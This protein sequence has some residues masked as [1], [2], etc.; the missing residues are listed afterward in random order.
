[1]KNFK[2]I[3]AFA[4]ILVMISG[5]ASCGSGEGNDKDKDG[6]VLAKVQNTEITQSEIDGYVS[7]YVL[8]TY[9][10]SKSEMTKDNVKYMEG[11][12]LNFAVETELLKDHYEKEGVDVLPKDYDDQFKSYKDTLFSQ[13]ENMQ[14]ELSD[15]G[16]DNDTLDFFFRSQFYTQKYM[17]DIDNEDPATDK[18]IEKYYDEHKDEFVS[19]AQIKASHILVADEKHSKESLKKIE[20]IR[21]K[22][23]SGETTF[24]KQAKANNT[25]STKDTGGDLGWF[26]KGQMVPEFE[27]AAFSLDVGELSDVVETTYGY[28]LIEVTDKQKEDQKSLKQSKKEIGDT[29]QSDKYADG[30]ESLKN[31]F[32]VEYTDAG[33]ELIGDTTGSA[34]QEGTNE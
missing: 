5:L 23:E 21:A 16:I 25:D 18:D 1:M 9:S 22:I 33:K 31:E 26:G 28:H 19:P 29:L 17:E 30:I 15:E 34:V 8:T 27:N 6:K 11:L 4:V 24:A 10:Q 2:K 14:S 13:S 3:I 7:Y 32:D 12:L 20:D